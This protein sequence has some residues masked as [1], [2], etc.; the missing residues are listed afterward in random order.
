MR[1]MP[2]DFEKP[3]L[4]MNPIP[5]PAGIAWYNRS[6]KVSKSRCADLLKSMAKIVGIDPACFSNKSGRATLITWMATLGVP[7]HIGMMITGHY[8][9]D[10]YSR[11][12]RSEEVKME[13]R[14]LCLGL[15]G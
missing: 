13:Q 9:A 2:E 8:S 14:I 12:D 11:Y 4:F 1:H 7:D 3:D 5:N 15:P 6:H 10:G